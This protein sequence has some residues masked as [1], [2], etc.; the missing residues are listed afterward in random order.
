[1]LKASKR[2]AWR[3]VSKALVRWSS[4]LMVVL[5]TLV[6]ESPIRANDGAWSIRVYRMQTSTGVTNQPAALE[7]IWQ[8]IKVLVYWGFCY[9]VM[10]GNISKQDALRFGLLN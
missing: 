2:A 7:A 4:R 9:P 8:A 10:L 1:M 3:M 5:Q 6:T